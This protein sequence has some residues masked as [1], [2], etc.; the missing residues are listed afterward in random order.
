QRGADGQPPMT[1]PLV[2]LAPG[3]R[4]SR[5][6]K[7]GWQLAGGHGPIDRARA[8]ADMAAFAEAGIATF[9][10]ADIYTGVEELIGSFLRQWRGPEV[11]VHTKYVPDLD[12][13]GRLS[14]PDVA[15]VIDRSLSR[16]GVERIDLVQF[17]WWDYQAPGLVET[18]GHL[19][20]LQRAGKIRHLGATNF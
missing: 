17:H 11:H 9:D 12:T 10:C 13:L 2:A 3:Y 15:R 4:I 5:L 1:V 20:D 6:I 14:R 16:L 7:G 19:V 8:I 18:A